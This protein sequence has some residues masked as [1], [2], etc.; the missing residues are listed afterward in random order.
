MIKLTG[1]RPTALY[2]VASGAEVNEGDFLAVNAS[3]YVSSAPVTSGTVILGVADVVSS[4][5]VM[6]LDGT[7]C[8]PNDVSSGHPLKRADRG[9]K[10]FLTSGGAVAATGDVIA[11]LVCDVDT[12][13]VWVTVTNTALAAARGL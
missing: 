7:V 8:V 10:C 4:G 3:G 6:L 9:K 11:G 1:E 12:D 5:G 2:P 13:G